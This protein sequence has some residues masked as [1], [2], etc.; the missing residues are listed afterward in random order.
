[1]KQKIILRESVL[2]IFILL[3]CSQYGCVTYSHKYQAYK[4]MKELVMDKEDPR[5]GYLLFFPTETKNKIAYRE[6]YYIQS[7]LNYSPK[8]KGTDIESFFKNIMLGKIILSCG[9]LVECFTLSPTIMNKYKMKK[10]DEFAKEYATYNEKNKNY[11]I[12]PALSNDE[13]LSVAYYFYL[14]NIYTVYDCYS[15]NYFSRKV[16]LHKIEILSDDLKEV[17]E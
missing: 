13:K 14:N 1:M 17:I 8:F 5:L 9:D 15:F 2:I 11:I 16:P 10:I 7:E 4:D 6:A 3:I 12:N